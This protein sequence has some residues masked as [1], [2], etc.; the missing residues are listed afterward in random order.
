M[1]GFSGDNSGAGT[2]QSRSAHVPAIASGGT[3]LFTAAKRTRVT[4]L[5]ASNLEG[6]ILP[7]SIYV[8]NSDDD[9]VYVIKNARV[10]KSRPLVVE[11]IDGDERTSTHILDQ[12][13]LTELVLSPGDE[14]YASTPISGSFDV[15]LT[16]REGVR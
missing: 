13:A 1:P 11:L 2:G 15:T 12:V 10:F 3:L 14:L 5:T 8:V 16:V 7:I 6:G 4:S 9:E